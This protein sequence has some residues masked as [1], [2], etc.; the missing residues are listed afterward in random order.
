VAL[1]ATTYNNSFSAILL[2]Q[3]LQRIGI[4]C[5]PGPIENQKLLQKLVQ[6]LRQKN[7]SVFL[8]TDTAR[9]IGEPSDHSIADVA[10]EADIIVVLGGDGTLLKV[11]REVYL[12]DTPLLAVNLGNL[13]FLTDVP[14]AGLFDA[15][16]KVLAGNCK[17]ESRM[18]LKSYILRDGKKT[19][20]HYVLND[21][22][23]SKGVIANI[24]NLEVRVDGQY[25]TSYRGDGLIVATPTGS[26]AYSLSAGGPIIHP[27]IH[28]LIIN[29]ICPCA[30]TNRPIII[31]DDSKIEINLTNANE[32]VRLTFDGQ[33]SCQIKPGDMLNIQKAETTLRLIR[34]SEKT[35]YQ[36][37]R[38][39]LNW[40]RATE[41]E[42]NETLDGHK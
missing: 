42:P 32:D 30:L 31:P 27:N 38:E 8:E 23:I 28:N 19:E 25:M 14:R 16:E 9:L 1:L 5:K 4:F 6:W 39:K 2:K 22:V 7:L 12:S 40:G 18:L 29:P 34:V 21:L 17:V 20:D 36:V 35:Y 24:V 41:P 33:V 37:L 3:P 11:T 13:G 26:T 15:L 10:K